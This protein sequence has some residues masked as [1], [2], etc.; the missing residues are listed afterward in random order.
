MRHRLDR[1]RVGHAAEVVG[2]DGHAA[3]LVGVP[4]LPAVV[5][6]VRLVVDQHDLDDLDAVL[7]GEGEV[8]LVVRRHA[9][10]GAVA[11]ADQHVVADPHRHLLV[12]DRVRHGQAGGHALLLLRGEL[13]LGGAAGLA[14]VD[15]GGD[16]GVGLA[17]HAAASGCS[18]ATAQKVTPMMV[19]ARVVKT[20]MR[21]SWI[22]WPLSSWMSCGEG[23]AHALALADPVLLHQLARARAS[24]AACAGCARAVPRRS[25]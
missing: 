14:F 11:V 5:V 10:H 19:S 8:A 9:H 6:E 2:V 16:L 1:L 13:G 15:E 3:L 20:Y 4:V 21:P 24:P 7:V 17:R 18:G 23:E 12:G 25:R 22:S